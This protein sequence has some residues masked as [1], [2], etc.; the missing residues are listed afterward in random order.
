M[1]SPLTIP[2]AAWSRRF[3][4]APVAPGSPYAP[5]LLD[6]VE[7]LPFVLRMRRFANQAHRQGR[8]PYVDFNDPLNPGPQMG[9]PLGG[10]GGGTITRGW[11]GGFVRWQMQPGI[12]RYGQVPADQFSVYVRHPGQ[13]AHVQV[14]NADPPD[15]PALAGW[16]W[17]MPGTEATYHALFPRAWTV[18]EGIAPGVRLTCRQVSP[19]IPHNYVESSF[20]AGVFVWDVENAG[21]Q[22]VTV[23]LMLTLQNGMGGP[24]DRAGGHTNRVF[25]LDA[26]G[27]RVRG[28]ELRHIH[29]QETP[30]GSAGDAPRRFEDLLSFAIAAQS[31]DG[32]EVTY[33]T[34]FATNGSGMDVWGD[35][36]ADG[37]LENADDV[38][39]STS[40]VPIGAALCATVEVEPG[41]TAQVPFSLAWD[42]P[43][44]RFG[45]GRGWFRRYTQ[46]YGRNGDAAPRIARDAIENVDHWEV[47][48]EA[49]QEPILA[50]PGLPDWYKAALF[51]EAYYLVDGGTIWID[52]PEDAAGKEAGALAAESSVGH[53]AYLAGHE[54]RVY[55][56]AD[57]HFYASFALASLWPEL[58]LGLQR[59]MARALFVEDREERRI[60]GTGDDAPRK[61]VGM[62]PHDF[63]GPDGDPWLRLN[64][65]NLQ[66]VSGWKDLNSKFVLQVYRDFVATQDIEFLAD[67]WEAV[68]AAI[69]RLV[70]FDLDGDGLIENDGYPDNAYDTWVVDGPSAYSGGLWLAALQ[71]VVGM[72]AMLDHPQEAQ[73]FRSLLAQGKRSYEELLWND[74][75][76]D[77]D[78]STNRQRD[79]L[80][81][82][83]LAGDWYARACGLP[84]IV[85]AEHAQSALRA[86][87][88]T[89]VRQFEGG[90]M[91]AV[92]GMRPD[93]R[94]DTTSM[95]SQE[96]W[97]G[98]T[99]AV[100]AAMLQLGMRDE[101]FEVAEGITRQNYGPL[102][103]WFMTPEA[104]TAN[105]RFRSLAAMRPLAIWAIQW[106]WERRA[107][108]GVT[109]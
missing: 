63:G 26:E 23:G 81:A 93:G 79:S 32:V 55:N 86:V 67:T 73:R 56:P 31:G 11:R 95:Q 108:A 44:A 70:D 49:W 46:F 90:E 21:D 24:N 40:G 65:Y 92:N 18:Y 71:A 30:A 89:N 1:F 60:V 51:N 38:R 59:D 3:D 37:A 53:F 100:A 45:E 27:G 91:G 54:N 103:M 75:Y 9:V 7:M 22:P 17:G 20:P 102:G 109:T 58:E 10:L 43:V 42:M 99:Y 19:V 74:T 48:I 98:T 16:V 69:D 78:A 101:A 35:F 76:Y 80:M 28:V 104:W 68:L 2:D 64:T 29:R 61:V 88:E 105:R 106:A 8:R 82:D 47:Q 13:K 4:D 57:A 34:R 84:G 107:G 87:L 52:G 72:A 50:D 6:M 77:Y 85:P 5:S 25:E 96:A 94:V 14:L 12:Y 33:R 36:V 66:D 15:S 39:P 83:Q 41:E 62:I 97:T